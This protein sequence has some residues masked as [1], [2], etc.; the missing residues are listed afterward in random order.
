[1][2]HLVFALT[3]IAAAVIFALLEIQIEG[4]KG[5]ATGLPT[6]RLE[7]AW[8]KRICGGRAMTGYH[9]YVHL[10]VLTFTHLPF[11]LDL[12]PW[13]LAAELRILGFILLFF[14]L[15][16]FLWFI[17]NKSFGLRRFRKEHIWWHAHAWWWI[18]PR[19]YWI[20][21]PLGVGLYVLS[22]VI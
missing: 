1:M 3:V 6:W 11:L 21:G 4:N 5:W 16:D 8:V 7:Q 13:T 10:L 20:A 14:I 18:M 17:F 22:V 12:A 19:D 15:E 2:A 9:F